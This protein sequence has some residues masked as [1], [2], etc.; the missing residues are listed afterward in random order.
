MYEL[1]RTDKWMITRNCNK[2]IESLPILTRNEANIEDILKSQ[3]ATTWRIPRDTELN[4]AAPRSA[5][6][7]T[8]SGVE[9]N[10]AAR[11]ERIVTDDPTSRAIWMRKLEADFESRGGPGRAG[12]CELRRREDG[13]FAVR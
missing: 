6:N 10:I 3:T 7:V 11:A 12:I 9:A 5:A 4:R 1:L 2:L 13:E 8:R